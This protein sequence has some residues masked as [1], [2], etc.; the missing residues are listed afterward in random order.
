[1]DKLMDN[2]WFI[3]IIALALAFL[4]YSS[5]PNSGNKL[6]DINV[7]GGQTT[8][9]ITNIPVK[10]YYDTENLVVSGIPD[11]VEVTIKGPVTHV[12]PAKVLKNFEVYVDLTN[13]KV[14]NQ[15]VKLHVRNLSDKLN[16]TLDP[17]Y[18]HVSIQEKITKEFKVDAEYNNRLIQDG[19]AAEQPIVEPNKVRIT[20]AK[21]VIDRI[22]YVKATLDLKQPITDTISKEAHIRVL[23]R[24]LNKLDV[25]VEPET[26]KVTV[27]IKNTSKVVPINVIQKGTPPSGVI[28]DSI[29]LDSTEATIIG[30]EDAI[31]V[32][33]HVRVEVDV[34]KIRDDTTLTLPIIISDGITKVS[35]QTVNASV[36]VKKTGQKTISSIPL[37]TR[38]L[39]DQYK[40]VFIDPANQIVNL[41]VSG[42]SDTVNRVSSEDFKAYIDLSNLTEGDHDVKIQIEGPP[43]INWNSNKSTA[44]ITIIK[45]NV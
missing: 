12:Q 8:A 25:I 37:N 44:K 7:P 36:K 31:K 16:V 42:P 19:F 40:L 24:E 17:A 11:T 26:V 13:A 39:S 15:T 33:D 9:T 35:P 23:D 41:S 30:K 27:P 14:G 21:D 45:N 1:M 10:V 32:T 4:L 20:G 3:K 43:D 28:I 6:S 38:G 18:A 2:P 5:V 22:T 34:S 29:S